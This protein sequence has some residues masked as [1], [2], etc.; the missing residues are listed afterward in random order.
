[1]ELN[2]DFWKAF[3][4]CVEGIYIIEE[5]SKRICYANDFIARA[6]I[7]VT[8]KHCYQALAGHKE[9]CDFCPELEDEGRAESAVYSWD[10]YDG[11]SKQWYKIKNRLVTIDGR[12]YRLG[13][14]NAVGDMMGLGCDAMKEMAAMKRLNDERERMR[15]LLEYESSHDKL[16]GVYNRNQYIS[17]LQGQFSQVQCAGILFFDLNNLKAVN[18]H[19]FHAEGDKLLCRLADA[20]CQEAVS[21][22]KCYRIG[23]DEFVL[24]VPNCTKHELELCRK[25]ILRTLEEGDRME[26]IPCDVAVGS[27]WSPSGKNLESLVSEA[28]LRMYENKKAMKGIK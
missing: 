1:M 28:D 10:F 6:G 15:K 17:D 16:T 27:A 21:G 11:R 7:A 25:R 18:D 13:N 23:G 5:Q 19:Y 8:G 2:M 22:N 20:I 9:P 12:L 4:P 3:L 26:A 14:V 24:I